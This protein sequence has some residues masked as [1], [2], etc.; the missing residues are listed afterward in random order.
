M[1]PIQV[2]NSLLNKGKYACGEIRIKYLLF[3]EHF[4][5]SI[6]TE[7]HVFVGYASGFLPPGAMPPM[8]TPGPHP[9]TAGI[10]MP[11]GMTLALFFIF[12]F[13]IGIVKLIFH[14]SFV[15][16]GPVEDLSS[17]PARINNDGTDGESQHL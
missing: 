8:G 12:I 6:L 15:V 13:I 16:G 10:H 3:E 14:N 17:D 2:V 4:S 5:L 7:K 9:P 11:P 1:L